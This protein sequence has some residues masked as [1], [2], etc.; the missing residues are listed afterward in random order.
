M[1]MYNRKVCFFC[2]CLGSSILYRNGKPTKPNELLD[3]DADLFSIRFAQ[4]LAIKEHFPILNDMSLNRFAIATA[5]ATTNQRT[6]R[7]N[8]SVV[9]NK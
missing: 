5:A 1:H 3:Y 9:S 7:T 2:V 6:E 8:V 4:G